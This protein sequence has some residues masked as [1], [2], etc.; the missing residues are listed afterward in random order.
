MCQGL[1]PLDGGDPDVLALGV[2]AGSP[3]YNVHD[4]LPAAVAWGG[5]VPEGFDVEL[6]PVLLYAVPAQGGAQGPA[7]E[8]CSEEVGV[9]DGGRCEGVVPRFQGGRAG[10]F[11]GVLRVHVDVW[12]ALVG[13]GRAGLCR[14]ASW[15]RGGL[16]RALMVSW[17]PADGDGGR[18]R[19][20]EWVSGRLGHARH[21]NG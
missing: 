7:L 18:V 12:L 3:E 5:Q 15:V 10:W 16:L 14:A 1:A 13:R 9:A 17:R 2:L 21:G 8:G 6:G 4:N 19:G 20:A 11:A